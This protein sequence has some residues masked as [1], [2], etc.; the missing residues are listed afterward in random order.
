VNTPSP[1]SSNRVFTYCTILFLAVAIALMTGCRRQVVIRSETVQ[2][3]TLFDSDDGSHPSPRDSRW[4]ITNKVVAQIS[5][6]AIRNAAQLPECTAVGSLQ[7]TDALNRTN[8]YSIIHIHFPETIRLG[9]TAVA[10]NGRE[11]LERFAQNGVPT[12]KLIAIPDTE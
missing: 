12:N 6:I 9:D 8:H 4:P 5:P 10:V 3:V 1:Y 11:L 2:E 7:T